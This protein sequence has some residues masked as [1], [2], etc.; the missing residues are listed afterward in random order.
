L[1]QRDYHY[2][3]RKTYNGKFPNYEKLLSQ[4]PFLF[5]L[6][7]TRNFPFHRHDLI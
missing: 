4:S 2:L 7:E 5:R 6:L 1:I 3:K